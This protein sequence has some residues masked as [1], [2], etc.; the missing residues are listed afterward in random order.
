MTKEKK[1]LKNPKVSSRRKFIAK[2][3][4]ASGV[5]VAGGTPLQK[6]YAQQIIT[7]V[8]FSNKTHG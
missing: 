4:A 2:A 8:T 1:S 5:I 7:L 6:R 3:A